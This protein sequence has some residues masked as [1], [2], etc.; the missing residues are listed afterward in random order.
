MAFAVPLE[1][2]EPFL[3]DDSTLTALRKIAD[4]HSLVLYCGAGVTRDRTGLGWDELVKSTFRFARRRKHDPELAEALEHLLAVDTASPKQRASLVYETFRRPGEEE[5]SFL[6]PYLHKALYQENGWSEGYLLRNVALLAVFCAYLDKP[7]SLVTTNYD[8]Y[9]DREVCEALDDF[10]DS[11]SPD[12]PIPGVRCIVLGEPTTTREIRAPINSSQYI[13]I[14]FIHGR[15]DQDGQAS[16]RVVFSENSYSATYRRTVDFLL[17]IF[18][19]DSGLLTLGASLTDE[20]L[21]EALTLTKMHA[22]ARFAMLT[23]PPEVLLDQDSA[24]EASPSL[25]LAK[26]ERALAKRGEHL[27]V[28]S[29]FPSNFAQVAQFVEE[30]RLCVLMEYFGHLRRYGKEVSYPARLDQW[31]EAWRHSSFATD[32]SGNYEFLRAALDDLVARFNSDGLSRDKEVLR[33]E[34][35]VRQDPSARRNRRLT[36]FANSTGPLMADSALRRERVDRFSQIASIRA[37]N[38]GKP[39]LVG[40]EDLEFPNSS[41]RWKTFLAAPI[42]VEETIDV[43][44]NGFTGSLPVGVVTLCSTFPRS[45]LRREDTSV[46]ADKSFV[47]DDYKEIIAHL[48]GAGREIVGNS[49]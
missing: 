6:R 44:G 38:E 29:L 17:P 2:S 10:F 19:K 4:C 9:L 11:P 39:I 22:G 43:D 27:G 47:N 15:V 31:W 41:T 48:L 30:L 7:V 49:R 33:L 28:N 45:E 40:L 36:L 23:V 5:T 25:T 1:G 13:E 14:N 32:H 18:G 26:I 37:F 46:L 16:G 34:V 42:F 3:K 20:P 35:W 12:E 24:R 21:I 8:D